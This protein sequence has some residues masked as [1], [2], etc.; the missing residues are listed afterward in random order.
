MKTQFE[1]LAEAWRSLGWELVRAFKID[2]LV[3]WLS[4]RVG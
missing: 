1:I 2:R 3:E 4:R